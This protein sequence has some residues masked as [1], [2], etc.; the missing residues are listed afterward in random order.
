MEIKILNIFKKK[1][2]K[3]KIKKIFITHNKFICEW[4]EWLWVKTGVVVKKTEA[5]NQFIK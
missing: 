3:F 2:L 4:M 5:K 1:Y